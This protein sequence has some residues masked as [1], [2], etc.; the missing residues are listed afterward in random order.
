MRL[1]L[2]ARIALALHLGGASLAWSAPPS[3]QE[4]ERARALMDAGDARFQSK[5]Y[6]SALEQYR[7]ADELMGVPTTGIEVGRTLERLGR[8]LEARDVLRRVSEYPQRA[9][10]PKPFSLARQRADRLLSDIAPRIPRVTVE[11]AGLPEGVTPEI[12]WDALRLDPA[13]VGGYLETDPGAHRVVGVAP[14]FPDVTRDVKLAEG[15]ALSV[16]LAFSH[17]PPPSAGVRPPLLSSPVPSPPV[18]VPGSPGQT[19]LFW[20]GAGVAAAGVAAGSAT[21]VYSLSKAR[22]AKEHCEGNACSPE[23]RGDLDGAKTFANVS[24]VAFAVGAAGL[25]LAVWQ[26]FS[27]RSSPATGESSGLE[28]GLS[29]GSVAISGRF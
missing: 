2:L 10:E 4:K 1:F 26:F 7:A 29:P 3:A 27:H 18:A 20:V 9:D 21:G 23:A 13:K 12:T 11:V 24:N 22:S 25:G 14:G 16:V 28:A 19:A 6:A 17:Q 8:L 15:Q 5:Q